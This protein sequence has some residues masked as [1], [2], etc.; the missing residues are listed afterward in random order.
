MT[1][2]HGTNILWS[3][4][5]GREPMNSSSPVRSL[6]P[7][8]P[9]GSVP[10]L[11]AR[12]RNN[13]PSLHDRPT[14]LQPPDGNIVRAGLDTL[15][16]LLAPLF[17]LGAIVMPLRAQPS[18]PE[19]LQR[20][21]HFADLY[22]WTDAAPEFSEAETLF[23]AAGDQRNALFARLGRIRA[24]SEQ[25]NLAATS[26]QLATE[27]ET[28]SI[29]RTDKQVRMFCLIVKGDIDEEFDP[30]AMRQ[31]WGQVQALAHDWGDTKWQYRSLAELG[32]AAFYEG[33][34]TTARQ[35]VASALQA[36]ETNGDAGAQI[37]YWTVLGGA[38]LRSN[39]YEQALP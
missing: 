13:D 31:D 14:A 39:M 17:V 18:A 37:R 6:C 21:L 35:N 33:D 30:R 9:V 26:A 29:L 25:R 4:N 2:R 38:L 16:R 27:L 10:F 28:N 32:M 15:L 34:L 8:G 12:D 1:A 5:E 23:L 20:A 22:N 11:R 36:A 7:K 24:T 3:W 19:G